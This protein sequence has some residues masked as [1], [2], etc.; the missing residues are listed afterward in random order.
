[1]AKFHGKV[2]Y[3]ITVKDPNNPGIYTPTIVERKYYG[4]FNRLYNTISDS[5]RLVNDFRLN[6]ELELMADGFAKENFSAIRYV[7]YM[8]SK[9]EVTS[10]Q[11]RGPR[12]IVDFGGVYNVESSSDAD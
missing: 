10:A 8:N 2:G 6:M 7:E 5:D 11:V 12:I 1:M 9:W 4:T 3:E